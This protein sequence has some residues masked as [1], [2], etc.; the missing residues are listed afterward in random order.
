MITYK[1]KVD[2]EPVEVRVIETS[3]DFQEAER[4]IISSGEYTLAFDTETTGLKL[5]SDT[6]KIRTVQ[7]GN[8]DVAY[9]LRLESVRDRR[10]RRLLNL[11][12]ER[13]FI[14]HN[15]PFDL[16]ASDALGLLPLNVSQDRYHD[17]KIL[18]HLVDPRGK[19]DGGVG[20]SLK[21]L[22][23]RY[24]DPS[25]PDTQNDLK[26]EFRKI[27]ATLQTG[28]ALIDINNPT[29][30]LYAGLDVILT[31]RLH[32][33]LRSMVNAEGYG[34]LARFE[35]EVQ[36][37]TTRMKRRGFTLDVEYSHT[38]VARLLEEEQKGKE[39][40]RAL[41]LENMN[42]TK[43][44]ADTL[45]SMGWE[46]EELTK[47]G[48]AKVDKAVLTSLL[49]SQGVT[50]QMRA[51]LGAIVSAKRAAK[52]N[53]A[54]AQAMLDARD[55]WDR[56]HPDI[57]SLQA[58]TS[59]MSIGNPPL[60]QL[61]SRGDDAWVIR[62][63]VIAR[64]GYVIGSADYDQVEFRV[65][66]ALANIS[67]MKYA[68]ANGI[69]LHD[70]T[71]Q[72]VYG[73]EFTKHQR[74]IGKG[75]GFGKV[76]GGGAATLSRQTGAPIDQVREAIRA[77]D[78]AYFELPAFAKSLQREQRQRGGYIVNYHGRYLPLDVGREYAAVN[79]SVQSIARDLLAQ[80]IVDLS[81]AG[82][83]D[84]LLLP[85]HDEVM[86][87]APKEDAK[88]IAHEV[89]RIMSGEFIDVPISASGE[90]YGRS[91]AHGYVYTD[92]SG[93]VRSKGTKNA[94]EGWVEA[95]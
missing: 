79:Y 54:Y 60:Q 65:L 48:N 16:L 87:E 64:E 56:V 44:V 42:S 69:D 26:D 78:E 53:K 32:K 76:F 77:Y 43:Q 88:D 62:R 90:V 19:M 10:A 25:A 82:L 86:F 95:E 38:L 31:A 36:R 5:F 91:W 52:W 12:S 29:Y 34:R 17:T 22:S 9:V 57:N 30:L 2:D 66:A 72:L 49:E 93:V 92:A 1:Y 63:Q 70:Y 45:R 61:P 18:S 58:R 46:P 47:T 24:V 23:A 8:G 89:G 59:R 81:T 84:Y 51:L 55:T 4:F 85:V 35:H 83:D 21:D 68:I 71:A 14:G 20:H 6:F 40:A 13:G 28:W 37:V 11:M 33:R 73:P 75:V 74:G 41:G 27:G 94:I 7:I 50:E 3:E 80:A 15:M 39:T 67:Q